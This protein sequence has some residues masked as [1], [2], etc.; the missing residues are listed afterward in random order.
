MNNTSTKHAFQQFQ[1]DLKE[2]NIGNIVFLCGEEQYLKNWA[3][4]MLIKEYVDSSTRELDCDYINSEMIGIDEIIASCETIPMMSKRKVVVIKDYRENF[5]VGLNNY[6]ENMP[7]TSLLIVSLDSMDKKIKGNVQSYDFKELKQPQLISFINKQ[8]KKYGKTINKGLINTLI[9]ES[10]YYNKDID[11][12]LYNLQ[13][14]IKKI[15]ALSDGESISLDDIRAGISDNIEHGVF[16]LIDAI[17][18]NRKDRAF[19]LLHQLIVSGANVFNL[20]GAIIS[21]LE[22]MLQT[23]ELMEH[24]CQL[25]E[26]KQ[27]IK[28]HEF[29]IKK[30]MSFVKKYS[31]KSLKRILKNAYA[32]D[33]KIKMGILETNMALEMLIA[34]I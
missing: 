17:S 28:V 12:S 22:I 3:I 34:E 13:G 32:T 33:G 31:E 2:N 23:K 26:I 24:G 11:Y 18:S 7:E 4:D 15:V 10:G 21:Q 1:S 29:R 25:K 9:E 27:N 5:Y 16:A 20:L 6:I 30:S 19:D 14:D 8:F